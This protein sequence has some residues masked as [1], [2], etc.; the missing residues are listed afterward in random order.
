[1]IKLPDCFTILKAT[2]QQIL[3]PWTPG[4]QPCQGKD[5]LKPDLRLR[6]KGRRSGPSPWRTCSGRQHIR[7]GLIQGHIT[8]LLKEVSLWTNDIRKI[9]CAL[10]PQEHKSHSMDKMASLQSVKYSFTTL[11]L[12][13]RHFPCRQLKVRPFTST[14]S[15]PSLSH[16]YCYI[17]G[18]ES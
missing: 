18:S 16:I 13:A 4:G 8:F 14:T 12:P 7:A 3:T 11:W 5:V 9:T 17:R 10:T 6:I 15:P 2:Y 1:M